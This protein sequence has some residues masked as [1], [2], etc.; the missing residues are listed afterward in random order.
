MADELANNS[1]EVIL[2][3]RNEPIQAFSANRA[4]QSL[5]EG[6]RLGC[7]GRRLQDAQ[8]E[9]PQFGIEIRRKD[10]VAVMD[11][12]SVGMVESEKLAELL[13][14]PLCRRMSGDVGVQNPGELISIA[15][16]TYKIWNEA[17]TGTKKSQATMTWA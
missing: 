10:T 11:H 14:S 2:S 7:S 15:T 8:S 5:A 6:V 4:N 3:Q 17:V 16:N 9:A 1:P 12:E 13:H